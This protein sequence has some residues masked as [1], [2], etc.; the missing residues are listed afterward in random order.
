MNRVSK[1]MTSLIG[2]LQAELGEQVSKKDICRTLKIPE[3]TLSRMLNETEG[4]Q[5]I[6]RFLGLLELFPNESVW[7]EEVR[8]GMNGPRPLIRVSSKLDLEAPADPKSGTPN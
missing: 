8:K 7:V 2:R 3:S 1:L 5:Q 4:L 6:D